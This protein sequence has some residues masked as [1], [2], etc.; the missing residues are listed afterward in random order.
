[1]Q[2]I[3]ERIL[4]IKSAGEFDSLALDVFRLQAAQNSVYARYLSLLKIDP[5]EIDATDKIPFLPIELFK[6]ERIILDNHKPEVIFRS[7]GTTGQQ[8]SIHFVVSEKLYRQSFLKTFTSFYGNPE[9]LC[10]LALLPS[11]LER[12]DSSLVYM[13]NHLVELSRHPGSGFY[14]NNLDELAEQLKQRNADKHPTLLLGVSFALLDLA[15]KYPLPLSENITV[16]ETGGMKGRRREMVREE[17][18]RTLMDAFKVSCIHSEYG[19]TELLSQAYAGAA[20]KFVSPPWM[21]VRIRDLY[22]PLTLLPAGKSG[23]EEKFSLKH[24]I[25]TLSGHLGTDV[26]FADDCMGD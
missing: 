6:T 1:M 15:E 19:M 12:D 23:P 7:S 16:M 8:P 17:L 11:Y 5:A 3:E 4:Q 13:M 20:G 2:P 9:G 26:Q 24:V 10:I 25:P 18:H 21:K 14:L 22:D